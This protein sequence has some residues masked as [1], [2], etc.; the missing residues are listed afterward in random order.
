[1]VHLGAVPI[2]CWK[3]I[4]KPGQIVLFVTHYRLVRYLFDNEAYR[5]QI[6]DL[7]GRSRQNTGLLLCSRNFLVGG[8]EVEI[9]KTGLPQH[10][11]L[12]REFAGLAEL[13]GD[14]GN[15]EFMFFRDAALAS[16]EGKGG[17]ITLFYYEDDESV[18]SV[19]AKLRELGLFVPAPPFD[20]KFH[21][22]ICDPDGRRIELCSP[23]PFHI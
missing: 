21:R 3:I 13:Y 19:L 2:S 7:H 22:I 16:S 20:E 23:N 12:S 18:A 17:A 9:G 1:M 8:Q 11:E 6:P 5:N 10:A 4:A 15:T 14:F